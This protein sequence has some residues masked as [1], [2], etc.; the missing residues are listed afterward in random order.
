MD[1]GKREL[2]IA[3]DHFP[4]WVKHYKGFERYRT[5]KIT[6]RNPKNEV[7]VK[8]FVGPTG[9]GKS[10]AAF[11]EAP[12]AYIMMRPQ[13]SSGSI[14]FDGYTGQDTVILEEFYGWLPWDFILRLFDRYPLRVEQKGTTVE[15]AATKFIITSNHFPE[16]WYP[17]IGDISPLLRD[18]LLK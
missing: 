18:A 3:Q 6:S 16:K 7:T 15:M 13:K 12:H 14:W 5:L 17:N 10:R 2:E 9:T 8:V 4:T 11:D 1:S